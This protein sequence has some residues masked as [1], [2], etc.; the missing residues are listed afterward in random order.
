M[1]EI[2]NLRFQFRLRPAHPSDFVER[3]GG[4][5]VAVSVGFVAYVILRMTI[6]GIPARRPDHPAIR[7]R[8]EPAKI[9]T[10]DTP[11]LAPD[12]GFSE[13][14]A[15]TI[16]PSESEDFRQESATGEQTS[17]TAD[18]AVT[19]AAWVPR[20]EVDRARL[21]DVMNQVRDFS[22]QLQQRENDVKADINRL[23][24]ESAGREFA[25]NTDGGRA[26]IIRLIDV[27]DFPEDLV[28]RVL[29]RYGISVEY[30]SVSPDTQSSRSFLNAVSTESGTFTNVQRDGYYEVFVLS[31][32]SV[33]MM[34]SMEL[35]ALQARG[36]D[37]LRTRTRSVTFGIVRDE[38][39]GE[40]ALDVTSMV[41]EAL[42]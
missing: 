22:E 7:I 12:P 24:I 29:A 35:R 8:L 36:H 39:Y 14:A 33:S 42:R 3:H 11:D 4:L 13:V 31:A 16:A 34:S 20:S 6:L 41:V 17:D 26:G 38:E 40:Y 18:D 27:T 21:E 32:K 1:H 2:F 37:P 5:S 19:I 30:R 23:E 28:L 25:L 9:V 10:E 15:T